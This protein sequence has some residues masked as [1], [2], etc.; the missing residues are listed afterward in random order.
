M[1]SELRFV[2]PIIPEY[3]GPTMAEREVQRNPEDTF[4]YDGFNEFEP[5]ECY[6]CGEWVE[7]LYEFNE[8]EICQTCLL[9]EVNKANAEPLI[10]TKLLYG[11]GI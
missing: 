8:E 3:I 10:T 9:R 11:D 4:Y 5:L 6:V 2:Y 7:K 1:D